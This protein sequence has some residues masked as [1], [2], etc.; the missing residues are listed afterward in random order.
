VDPISVAVHRGSLVESRHRVHAV[1]V[2][3]G[4][5]VEAWGDPELV[6]FI[7]SAAKPLQALPTVA[8]GLSTDELAI[9]CASHTAR[10]EQLEAVR[11]LLA[12][13]GSSEDDLECGPED[14]SRLRH[15]CSGKHAG[16]LAL[17]AARGWERRGY[18]LAEHPLQR[19]LRAVLEEVTESHVEQ[20]AT[21]GC[22]VVTYALTLAAAAH[23]FARLVR[24]EVEGAAE[25][26]AAMTSRPELVEGRGWAATEVMLAVPGAVAKG[27]AEGLLCVGLAD[28]TAYALKAE[29]GTARAL[30]PAAGLLFGLP[31]LAETPM[32]NS[33]GEEVGKIRPSAS[34]EPL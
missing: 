29:D 15:N 3:G 33:R 30:A 34:S 5:I 7:R 10:P 13:S 31:A 18:R 17:C 6:T 12:R 9:A 14:G 24:G 25:V 28:G 21:D 27:G 1:A 16:M 32:L 20:T 19:E 22:G 2:R 23:G 4:G 26:V 11:T 8:L